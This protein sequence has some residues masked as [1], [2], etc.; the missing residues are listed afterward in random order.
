MVG[1]LSRG[2][3]R[4]WSNRAVSKT[5]VPGGY[6]GFESHLSANNQPAILSEAT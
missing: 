2:E 3:V 5:A 1:S 6:R 4:E